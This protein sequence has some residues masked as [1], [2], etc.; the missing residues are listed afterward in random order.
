MRIVVISP[1]W[2]DPRE[3][4]VL[5]GLFSEGLE[6]YHVR[7]PSWTEAELEAWLTGLPEAWR[8]RLFLH[9]HHAL[10]GKLRLGGAHEKDRDYS[11]PRG[12][13]RSCHDLPGL[14]ES[15]GLYGQILLGPIFP[16]LSKPGHGPAEAL[17][18]EDLRALLAE[19]PRS[20][21]CKVL[22]LGGITSG[23]LA[24]CREMGFDGAAVLGAVWQADD[25]VRS[26]VEIRDAARREE[27][28]RHA[29]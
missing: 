4:P 13:S 18:G 7:K 25:P 22:A 16:S 1:D 12:A 20:G 29:A 3:R 23:S 19:H 2:G 11:G 27:V 28:S 26:F 21:D 15:L 6:R 10:V 14:R 17:H 5:Q 24:R 9:E 8:P